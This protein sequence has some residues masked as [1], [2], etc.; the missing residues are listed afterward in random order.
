MLSFGAL[1]MV[2]LI[3]NIIVTGDLIYLSSKFNAWASSWTVY[4]DFISYLWAN[5]SIF[6]IL[7]F[8]VVNQTC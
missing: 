1:D 4:I 3:F 6:H 7:H 5:L 2:S 8:F